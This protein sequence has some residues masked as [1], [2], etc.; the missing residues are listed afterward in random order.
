MRFLVFVFSGLLF[1]LQGV[2][3]QDTEIELLR[4][5]LIEDALVNKGFVPRVGHY[6]I[7]DF[8]AAARYLAEQNFDGSWSSVDYLDTDNS[9]DPLSALDKILVMSVA[10]NQSSDPLYHNEKLLNGIERALTY[11]YQVDPTCVNWYKNDI[12]KQMYQGPI[13]ILM[14]DHIREDLLYKIIEDQT[15]A[16]RMTGSNRT[17]VSTSVFYRGVLEKNPARIKS[18]ISGVMDPVRISDDEG[19]QVDYSFHQHGP[20]LYNGSY[21]SNFLRETA[22]IAS[23]VEGTSYAF[24]E[25]HIR[26]L[27]DYFLQGTRWMIWK[28][29]FDYNARGRQVGR[30]SGFGLNAD[31][32]IPILEYLMAADPAFKSGYLEVQERIKNSRPQVVQGLKH[33]WRSDYSVSYRQDFYTTLR[34][35]SERT[36]G[37]ETDVNYEN[38]LGRYLPY[39]LTYIY[40][41][42][43]E[44]EEI[45]PV[46][47]WARLPG[48]TSPDTVPVEKGKYTQP[49]RFVGGVTDGKFGLSAMD[50]QLNSTKGKKVW[51]WFEEGFVALGAG[52]KSENE[53]TLF[54]GINQSNLRGEVKVNGQTLAEGLAKLE[55]PHWVWHDSTAYFFPESSENLFVEAKE[56]TGNLKWIFGLS[57]DTIYRKEVFSLWFDHGVMPVDDKYVY[58]VFPGISSD[59]SKDLAKELPVKVL[60]NNESLQV[61]EHIPTERIGLAFHEVTDY[62]ISKKFTLSVSDPCL[63]LIDKKSRSLTVSDPTTELDEVTISFERSNGKKHSV[64]M[65]LPDDANASQ[66]KSIELNVKL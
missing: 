24:S 16:P 46:W 45:F 1:S 61:I 55:S 56:K 21:G 5:R 58:A 65:N 2:R 48:V 25:D 33:F 38:L 43:D 47:N 17:L 30:P 23:M 35:C 4:S 34:M 26:I 12:A 39:G 9:W 40:R 51:F 37:M 62:P 63:V 66:S 41:R 60:V 29:L 52:I 59:E 36:I 19:I 22:W 8:D 28:E 27:R 11:W 7:P 20:F 15:P 10:Y 64:T 54:T 18:G 13:A 14:Q 3:S 42:G 57:E 49:S 50:L 44:Y 53:H 32:Q 6:I 31:L